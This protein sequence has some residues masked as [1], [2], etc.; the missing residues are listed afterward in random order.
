MNVWCIEVGTKTSLV[1]AEGHR[2]AHDIRDLG[3]ST[4]VQVRTS[5]LY[6]LEGDLNRSSAESLGKRL[7]ADP[8]AQ[9]FA[10]NEDLHRP[11]TDHWIVEV[12]LKPGVTDAVGASV[13]K[14][15]R[16]IGIPGLKSVATGRKYYLIGELS[17]SQA[18]SLCERLLVNEVIHSY[19][20]RHKS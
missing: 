15:A 6:W 4:P 8:I 17:E 18:R 20:L 7:L 1:D 14:G 2:I 10:L 13:L 11:S 19:R 9:E 12:R 3:I 5:F 16:D